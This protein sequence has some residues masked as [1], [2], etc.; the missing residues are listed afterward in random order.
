MIQPDPD[1]L[2]R[3]FFDSVG[4][5]PISRGRTL[6]VPAELALSAIEFF[7]NHGAIVR[8]IEGFVLAPGE[9]R[10]LDD[11]VADLTEIPKDGEGVKVS[12][13]IANHF[14]AGWTKPDHYAFILGWPA[15]MLDQA[16]DRS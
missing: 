9:T 6:Y 12:A 1:V 7:S 16:L 3:K 11:H 2:I 14:V 8:G 13:S 4:A 10:P 15:P 5:V